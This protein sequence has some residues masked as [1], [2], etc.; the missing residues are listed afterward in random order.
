MNY[1]AVKK[2]LAA[3]GA[4]LS[5]GENSIS[6]CLPDGTRTKV[7]AAAWWEH[8]R[9]WKLARLD[10]QDNRGGLVVCLMFADLFDE[11]AAEAKAA[12]N[13]AEVE[14]M[15][16]ERDDMLKLFFGDDNR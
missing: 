13:T 5:P 9:E 7:D 4:I 8:R 14:R 2:R 1:D 15:T 3:L 6:V 10:Q 16:K 11:G 12:G